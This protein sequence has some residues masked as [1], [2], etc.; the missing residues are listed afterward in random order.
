MCEGALPLRREKLRLKS[1][2]ANFAFGRYHA[3]RYPEEEC[4]AASSFLRAVSTFDSST[5]G[6]SMDFERIVL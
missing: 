3:G 6:I 4:Y 1:N 2:I 5:S